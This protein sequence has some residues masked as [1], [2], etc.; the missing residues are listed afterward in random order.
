MAASFAFQ[1]DSTD[2]AAKDDKEQFVTAITPQSE[3]FSR[4]YTDVVRRAELADYSPVKGCMVIRPYGYAIWEFI[5]RGL[6]DRIKALS[7]ALELDAKQQAELRKVLERQRELGT[8][9]AIGLSRGQV[10]A[11]VV[12][13]AGLL[14][15]T[16]ISL[17]NAHYRD[18]PILITHYS[19]NFRN[20]CCL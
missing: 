15:M 1:Q 9:R 7:K 10:R 2:M 4:W 14:G 13:E 17:P 19:L 6:D 16:G 12:I 18:E 11:L 5:Q 3:D 20:T 8:L